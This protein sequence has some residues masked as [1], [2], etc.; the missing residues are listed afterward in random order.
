MATWD[1]VPKLFAGYIP[2][3]I[4][5]EFKANKRWLVADTGDMQLYI[6][7]LGPGEETAKEVQ[8]D[9]SQFTTVLK[10]KVVVVIGGRIH[11]FK[12]QGFT[13]LVPAGTV[14]QI[15]NSSS[16]KEVQLMSI[17]NKRSVSEETKTK[18]KTEK[19]TEGED[20]FI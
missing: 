13:F 11:L 8:N 14:H 5:S 17:Y 15:Q 9:Y 7:H 4:P 1:H 6:H 19:E 3:Y 10:G 20:L 2:G 18:T 12:R 16:S